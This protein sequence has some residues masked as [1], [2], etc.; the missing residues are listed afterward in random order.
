MTDSTIVELSRAYALDY[1]LHG[2][3]DSG[4][5]SIPFEDIT[6]VKEKHKPEGINTRSIAVVSIMVLVLA[7][8]IAGG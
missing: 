2:T 4:S 5:M 7:L 3:A 8:G 1:T 6:T